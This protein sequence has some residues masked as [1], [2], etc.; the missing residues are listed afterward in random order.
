MAG[1]E[2][3]RSAMVRALT[4][5]LYRDGLRAIQAVAGG[6][7][8]PDLINGVRPDATGRDNLFHLF[9]VVLPEEIPGDDPERRWPPLAEYSAQTGAKFYVVVPS[10]HGDRVRQR[11]RELDLNAFIVEI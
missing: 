7:P 8:R 3:E 6:Y 9:A 4:Q 5:G 11:L 1:K 2:D 10:S